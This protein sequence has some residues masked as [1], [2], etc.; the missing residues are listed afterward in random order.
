MLKLKYILL[1]STD[2]EIATKMY[3]TVLNANNQ[4]K[5]EAAG[6]V[7]RA[8]PALGV[9]INQADATKFLTKLSSRLNM[10]ALNIATQLASKQHTSADAIADIYVSTAIKLAKEEF[11]N[12]I[13]FATKT[14]I[15]WKF[16]KSE[17]QKELNSR[18]NRILTL[19]HNILR[20]SS[21]EL[22]QY[23]PNNP[24]NAIL[25]RAIRSTASNNIQQNLLDWILVQLYS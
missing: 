25:H 11:N 8:A 15:K 22:E 19:L 3:S 5:K 17:M 9:N 12:Q 13:G 1:E 6:Y 23:L 24:H 10:Q 21:D 20:Y 18:F 2:S 16:S 7:E 4:I 14:A